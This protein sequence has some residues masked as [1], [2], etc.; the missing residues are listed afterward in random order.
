MQQ[1]IHS[2]KHCWQVREGKFLQAT[3]ESDDL[4]ESSFSEGVGQNINWNGFNREWE[5]TN[6][7]HKDGFFEAFCSSKGKNKEIKA[8]THRS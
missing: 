7:R 3:T 6:G 5:K 2:V 8:V 1:W 4:N